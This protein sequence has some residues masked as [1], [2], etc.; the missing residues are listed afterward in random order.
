MLFCLTLFYLFY[1]IFWFS[2]VASSSSLTACSLCYGLGCLRQW[3]ETPRYHVSQLFIELWCHLERPE[4]CPTYRRKRTFLYNAH[5]LKLLQQAS[6]KWAVLRGFTP[7]ASTLVG[8]ISILY[9]QN[10]FISASFANAIAHFTLSRVVHLNKAFPSVWNSTIHLA[11]HKVWMSDKKQVEIDRRCTANAHQASWSCFKRCV[12]LS[13]LRFL[14]DF[15]KF[16]SIHYQVLK[17]SFI[18]LVSIFLSPQS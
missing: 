8:L 9:V 17:T 6:T 18:V 14:T 1:I 3:T 4:R 10:L 15:L 13:S 7:D 12:K 2:E 16:S 5:E 11:Y